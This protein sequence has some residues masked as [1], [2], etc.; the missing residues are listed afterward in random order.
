MTLIWIHLKPIQEKEY[1]LLTNPQIK[2]EVRKYYIQKGFCQPRMDSYP[3]TEIGSRMRQF[4]K[5]WFK[6]PYSKWLEYSVE[7]DYVYCLCCYL[8]KDEFFH[9]SKSEFY[10]KSGFRSWNKAL[11]RFHKHVGDVNHI[12]GK[13]FNKVLDLSIYYQSIQVAF[14]KHFQKLKNST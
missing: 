10:T 8:F 13:C 6:G 2:N 9:K 12:P 7:K 5:S 14:D 4:C 1:Q 3:L 11:E